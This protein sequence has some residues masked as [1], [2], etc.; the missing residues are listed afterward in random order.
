MFETKKTSLGDLDEGELSF[1]VK[2]M[3][4]DS[5]EELFED[6]DPD[7]PVAPD[8][9]VKWSEDW[10]KDALFSVDEMDPLWMSCYVISDRSNGEFWLCDES[11]DDNTVLIRIPSQSG[12]LTVDAVSKVA[13]D[14]LDDAGDFMLYGNFTIDSPEWL[15]L[16][17]VKPFMERKM[18]EYGVAS[19]HGKDH[20]ALDAWL[21]RE[22]GPDTQADCS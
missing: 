15:P 3:G 7:M 4:G 8:W 17:A 20:L 2:N 13:L 11:V 22:Y 18:K 1:A 19:L 9:L 6:L 21:V 10:S 14:Y 5:W 16:E 12:K